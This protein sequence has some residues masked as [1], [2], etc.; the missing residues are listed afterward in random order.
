MGRDDSGGAIRLSEGKNSARGRL[1]LAP[2]S[3]Q[4][5]WT[6]ENPNHRFDPIRRASMR[7]PCSGA[8][9]L[10]PFKLMRKQGFADEGDDRQAALLQRCLSRAQD[11]TLQI[12]GIGATLSKRS[13]RRPQYLQRPAPSPLPVDGHLG[14][15][16]HHEQGLRENSR[17]ENSHQVVRRP[18][19]LPIR[20]GGAM[21]QR[22]QRGTTKVRAPVF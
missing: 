6:W 14:L 12:S 5:A 20:S 10:R 15:S 18:S 4:G 22:D 3:E 11:A 19:G 2:P 16:C 21:A 13:C 7:C 9:K 17:A 8:A 1:S